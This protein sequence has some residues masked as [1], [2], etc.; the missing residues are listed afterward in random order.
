MYG[1]GQLSSVVVY[2]EEEDSRRWE[3]EDGEQEAR[4]CNLFKTTIEQHLN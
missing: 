1:S 2:E 3:V 4:G